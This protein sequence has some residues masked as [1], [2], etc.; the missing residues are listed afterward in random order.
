MPS[1]LVEMPDMGLNSLVPPSELEPRRA[2]PF[3]QNCIYKNGILQA[4][5]GFAKVDQ[6]TTGLNSGDI[7]LAGFGFTESDGTDHFM[8]V[9][10]EKIYEHDMVNSQWNDLTQSGVTMNSDTVHPISWVAIYHDDTDI[11]LD[12]NTGRVNAYHHLIICDGGLSNIQRWAGRWETDFADVVGAGGYHDGTTHRALQVNS[13]MSRPI[14][15]SPQTYSSTSKAWTENNQRIQWPTSGKLQTWTGTGSGSVNLVETNDIN[16]WSALLGNQFIIYQQHSIWGL[17]YI[18]GDSVFSPLPLMDD[19]GLLSH[20]LL[21]SRNNAHYFVGNDYNVYAYFGGSIKQPI[22][23]EIHKDLRDKLNPDYAH[24]CWMVTDSRNEF[25]KIYIVTSGN[26]YATECYSYNL[27][28]NKWMFEDLSRKWPSASTGISAVG[29]VGGQ[30]YTIGETYNTALNIMSAYDSADDTNVSSG[31]V[32]I[33]YGDVL[34]DSTGQIQDWTNLSATAEYDFSLKAGE[35][36]FSAGGL[37]FC[38][39]YANDPT[40]L[41]GDDTDFSGQ[42]LRYDDGSLSTNMPNG[43]HYYT[44]LDVCSVLDAG[45]DYTVTVHVQPCESTGT[46]IADTSSDTPVLD[47]TSWMTIFDPSGDT[48]RQKQEEVRTGKSLVFGDA[49]GFIYQE[50]EDYTH[51]DGEDI[52]LRHRTP[53]FDF[54]NPDYYK[55]WP[56]FSM[57]GKGSA[58]AVRY[59]VTNFDTSDTSWTNILS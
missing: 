19:L 34:Y 33:K 25:I 36:D 8:A 38:F 22:G 15:I 27:K 3:S 50:N 5:Y 52:L 28:T 46:A 37:A 11:Y 26:S 2:A 35:V 20:N 30:T 49:T 56:A 42:I 9:T 10:T 57:V 47:G 44:M 59:R 31:D 40:R 51:Y 29:I 13:F 7:V 48:Y 21:V 58:V 55:R 17:N 45:T 39:S 12:D 24:R 4:P 23:N 14:L 41:V 53:I 16:V 32:T 43:S 54:E 6:T 18:G 1:I